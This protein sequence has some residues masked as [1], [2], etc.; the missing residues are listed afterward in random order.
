MTDLSLIKVHPKEKL[1]QIFIQSLATGRC[2]LWDWRIDRGTI[3]ISPNLFSNFGYDLGT[4][5]I[6][7]GEL[8]PMVHPEDLETLLD[9]INACV[10][11]DISSVQITFRAFHKDSGTRWLFLRGRLIER[12]NDGS[13]ARLAGML[14]DYTHQHQTYFDLS[15]KHDLM[16]QLVD[17]LPGMAFGA[18]PKGDGWQIVYINKGIKTLLG[19]D[20]DYYLK[21]YDTL[22][23]ELIHP[24]DYD[25]I[26]EEINQAIA[27]K[28]PFQVYYRIKTSSSEHKWVWEQGEVLYDSNGSP[29][30]MQC[31]VA[32]VT[33]QKKLEIALYNENRRLKST[34]KDRFHMGDII[35]KSPAM[36]KVYAAIEKAADSDANVIVYGESGTGKEL[37]ARMIH[38]L[39][40]R[41][42]KSFVPVNCG[43]I[44]EN[45]LESEFFGYRK[46]AFSG[47]NTDTQGY[48]AAA[49]GGTLFLDELEEISANFQVKL[50]RILDGLGYSPLG[51]TQIRIPDLRIIAATNQNLKKLMQR[52][53]LREDFYYRIHVIPINLPPL[54]E[55]KGDIPL[56]IDHFLNKWDQTEERY[57]KVN[58]LNISLK[59]YDWPGNVRELKNTVLRYIALGSTD[60]ADWRP[61][62]IEKAIDNHP[63][64]QNSLVSGLQTAMRAHE[65]QLILAALDTN[66]WRRDKTA[67]ALK[68]GP[69]T[70]YRKMK[71]YR[72]K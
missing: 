4:E 45:L 50:L 32:D 71:D 63:P 10:K 22:Y 57:L 13:P 11:G 62:R 39:S 19:Y 58:E 65:K 60:V 3:A 69:R 36:Q 5:S 59:D 54:R 30:L 15:S 14:V 16:K 51:T 53:K 28:R 17:N 27:E 24:E 23:P 35:G 40:H 49:D 43:A 8:K 38:N 7:I 33:Q 25:R 64:V 12:T 1:S 72:L 66:N 34:L 29:P 46:G 9:S 42:D 44:P 37:V 31:F 56:L 61:L 26:W 41:S 47:A 70:L 67:A 2:G 48:L 52:K 20:Y 21:N 18:V 68:I 6:D 55:R